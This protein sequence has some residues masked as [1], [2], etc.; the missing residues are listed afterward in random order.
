M[1]KQQFLDKFK[2]SFV[3]MAVYGLTADIKGDVFAKTSHML[4]VTELAEKHLGAMYDY[5]SHSVALT[6]DAP[7]PVLPGPA[8][9]NPKKGAA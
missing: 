3:G 2:F 8:L 4:T 6:K 1:T 9:H 7:A 5:L